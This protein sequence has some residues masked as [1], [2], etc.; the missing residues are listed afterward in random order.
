MM[1]ALNILM[2]FLLLWIFYQ[3]M[4]ERQVTLVLLLLLTLVGGFLNYQKQILEIFLISSILN[5]M[6]ILMVVL[7][8]WMYAKFKLKSELFHVFGTGDLL[9]FF[10]LA[11]SFP[12]TTFLVV[13][14]S[15]LIFSLLV[16]IA[17]KKRMKKWIPLAG[18]QALFLS[19]L[20]G[21]NQVFQIV[22]LYAL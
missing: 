19:L 1:M 11:V 18:L 17:L 20:V 12:I 21:V 4:K 16:S 14:S 15:S 13:F 9:F 10:F 22:N 7:I 6:V 2:I 3:D 8:L 5:T